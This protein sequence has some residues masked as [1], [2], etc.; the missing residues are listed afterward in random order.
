MQ[1][2]SLCS[3][4][5]KSQSCIGSDLSYT[6]P[7]GGAWMRTAPGNST[8]GTRTW[9]VACVLQRLP[10]LCKLGASGRLSAPPPCQGVRMKTYI[11]YIYILY[12][13]V[14]YE[15]SFATQQQVAT[16][17]TRAFQS[18][19][20]C[21]ASSQHPNQTQI[22]LLKAKESWGGTGEQVQKREQEL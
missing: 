11:L 16:Q 5:S 15:P 20:I 8:R 6:L 3:C 14:Q 22:H 10:G 7:N 9:A 19:C 13:Y 4:E 1:A 17:L 21:V 12:V 2:S 18:F